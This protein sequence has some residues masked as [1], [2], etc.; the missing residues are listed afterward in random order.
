MGL[1]SGDETMV[2]TGKELDMEHMDDA[3]DVSPGE[4]HQAPRA[5]VV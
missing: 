5:E 4:K 3:A 1:E 2:V